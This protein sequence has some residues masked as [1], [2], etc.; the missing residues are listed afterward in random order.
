MKHRRKHRGKLLI[1]I[2]LVAVLGYNVVTNIGVEFSDSD[3][4]SNEKMPQNT[5]VG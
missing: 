4:M 3:P 2:L 1:V 5:T